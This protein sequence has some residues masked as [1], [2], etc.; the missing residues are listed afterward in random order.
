MIATRPIIVFDS[1]IG[2]LSIYRPLKLALPATPIVYWTDSNNFPYGNKS[3]TWLSKRFRELATDFLSLNPKLL[4][5]ACNSATTNIITELRSLLACPVVGV[6]P[7]IKPLSKYDSAL[8]LMTQ[9]TAD[10]PTTQRLLAQYGGHVRVF[11]PKE[12]AMAIEYNDYEQV[13]KSIHEIKEIVQKHQVQA[14]GLSCT[15]YPLILTELKRA[16]AKLDFIDPSPAV[17]KEVLRVLEST[18]A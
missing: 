16:M 10:S 3:P 6:E 14:I 15:H 9:S 8:A 2:G 5:L 4:V 17:V 11:C 7:V 18:S 1:G 12:L 13:K